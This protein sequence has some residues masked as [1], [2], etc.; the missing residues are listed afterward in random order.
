MVFQK[1]L[2][3]ARCCFCYTIDDISYSSNELSF[4]LFADNTNL[5]YADK[6]LRSLEVKPWSNG[7]A[8][9]RKLITWGYLRLRLARP[10]VHLR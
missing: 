2:Y 10:C 9:S 4:F 6:N 5:L 3:W 1:V 8:S 7:H